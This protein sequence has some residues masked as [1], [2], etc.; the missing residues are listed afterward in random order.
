MPRK[1]Q[2][3]KPRGPPVSRSGFKLDGLRFG[4]KGGGF[5]GLGRVFGA[6]ADQRLEAFRRGQCICGLRASGVSV[7]EQLEA[8]AA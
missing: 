8:L 4:V 3:Q 7:Q 5:R 6:Q 1:T 2:C